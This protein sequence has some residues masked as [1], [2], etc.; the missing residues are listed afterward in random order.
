MSLATVD[1]N[2]QPSVRMVLLKEFD[3]DGFKFYTNLES[4]KSEEIKHNPK[5]ALCL[6]WETLHRQ[7]RIRGKATL[8]ARDKVDTYFSSRPIGAQISATVSK[9]S[10]ELKSYA[11]LEKA[12]EELKAK[13]GDKKLPTPEHWGGYIVEASDIEFWQGAKNRLHDRVLYTKTSKGLWQST[14]LNP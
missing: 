7:I 4:E 3:Q 6:Y 5:V 10:R 1:S 14:R 12:C 8:L 9:Q 13:L 11:E 2:N